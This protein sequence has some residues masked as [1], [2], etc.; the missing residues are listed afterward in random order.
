MSAV[1]GGTDSLIV[2]PF[3]YWWSDSERGLRYARNIHHLLN[4]ESHLSAVIDPLK[5]SYAVEMITNRFVEKVWLKF[6]GL[7]QIGGLNDHRESINSLIHKSH[8]I[9]EGELK[10]GS[11]TWLGVNLHE[12]EAGESA[13][14]RAEFKGFTW[15]EALKNT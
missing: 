7:M 8:Q 10:S 3:D 11:K 2:T 1:L 9:L 4:E 5:G 13:V 6:Q 15:A 12:A 14:A